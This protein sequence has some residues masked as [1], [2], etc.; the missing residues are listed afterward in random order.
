MPAASRAAD[1][2][3]YL[4]LQPL[5]PDASRLTFAIGSIA[6]VAADGTEHPLKL[7]LRTVGPSEGGRQRLLASGRVPAGSYAGISIAFTR[8]F[9]KAPGGDADLSVGRAPVRV[10][11]PFGAGQNAA[12]L[13]TELRY[14]ESLGA[15]FAFTPVF[16]GTVPPRPIPDHAG[17][18]TNAAS[19]TIIVFDKQLAQAVG[20]IETCGGPAGMALDQR[21]RRLY[22]AC[23]KDDEVL[24]I[25]VATAQIIER[26][27]VSPGERPRELALSA[28]GLT[29]IA[30]NPGSN[31]ITFFDALSLSRGE[32]VSVGT[33]PG[34]LVIEPAGR[35]VFVFNTLASSVSVVDLAGRTVLT[36]IALDGAPLRGKFN[37]RGD[38]LYVI[39]ERSPYMS[40]ID[41]TTL[42][43]TARVRLQTGVTAIE[44]DTV[45]DLV[46]V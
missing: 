34:S 45:R 8:A 4:Y 36:T 20:A 37:R 35:R 43:V 1:G 18:V 29:L 38:R 23:S 39:H 14:R 44:V 27:R 26:T 15:G 5:P 2:A 28:D 12:L 41:V 46:C 21:R 16:T 11:V 19:N 13:W 6:A 24:A 42:A 30:A 25:D 22:V 40:V 33:A 17:F 7:H 31:T 3:V 10:D 9:L 32:R